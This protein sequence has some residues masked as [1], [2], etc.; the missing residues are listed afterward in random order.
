MVW[1]AWVAWAVWAAWEAWVQLQNLVE[2][3]RRSF[4]PDLEDLQ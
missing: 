2:E 4:L 1:V 3:L